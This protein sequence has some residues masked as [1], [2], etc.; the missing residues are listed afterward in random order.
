MFKLKSNYEALLENEVLQKN[1]L[2]EKNEELK[3]ALAKLESQKDENL[4]FA[5][6][7]KL[8]VIDF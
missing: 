7:L 5:E 1:S 3:I 6:S 2:N 4:K 8:K